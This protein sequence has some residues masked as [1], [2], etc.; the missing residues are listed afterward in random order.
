MDSLR[1]MAL[2]RLAAGAMAMYG[3]V[4]AQTSGN[5]IKI[6]Q[7]L[8]LSGLQSA[9]GK[10]KRIGL[11]AYVNW[12]KAPWVVSVLD[13]AYDPAKTGELARAAAADSDVLS[14]TGIFGAPNCVAAANVA[15]QMQCPVIGL[16][17]GS[18]NVREP[19]RKF[20]FPV[21]AGFRREARCIAR[22]IKFSSLPKAAIVFIN[23]PFGNLAKSSYEAALKEEGIELVG[24]FEMAQDGSN[25]AAVHEQIAKLA[26]PV[27]LLALHSPSAIAFLKARSQTK[28]FFQSF[29]L[30]AVDTSAVTKALGANASGLITAQVVPPFQ[31]GTTFLAR[32]YLAAMKTLP[33]EAPSY[34][35]LE[36]FLEARV[37]GE[38]IKRAGSKPTRDSLVRALETFQNL[39]LGGLSVSYGATSRLGS[40]FTDLTIIGKSGGVVS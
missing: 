18:D 25:A 39:D 2:K 6:A 36:A 8:P 32:D 22:H 34:Y 24:S 15:E 10:S 40:S 28:S 12:A 27:V 26:P 33:N 14:L 21:R 19:M 9:Y 1:R 17:T 11:A 4:Q 7:V 37:L 3:P 31:F 30:S 20:V 35:G 38:A 13:D 16:T 29:A 5:P 23:I